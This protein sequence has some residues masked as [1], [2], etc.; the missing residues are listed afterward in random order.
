VVFGPQQEEIRKVPAFAIRLAGGDVVAY[1]RICPRRGCI[2]NYVAAPASYNCGCV[3]KAKKCCCAV[4]YA[5]PLLICP[6]DGSAFDVADRGRVVN[7]PAPR[8]PR[9]FNVTQT[10]TLITITGLEQGGIA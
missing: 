5:T 1:S 3:P 2:I 4:D 10:E 9:R 7:G 6:C 8:P